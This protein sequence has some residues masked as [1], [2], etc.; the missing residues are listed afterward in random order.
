MSNADTLARIARKAGFKLYEWSGCYGGTLADNAERLLD[1]RTHYYDRG[2]RAYFGSRVTK[3]TTHSDGTILATCESVQHPSL[4]RVHRF[5]IFDVSGRV[6]ER[7]DLE[8]TQYR[9]ASQAQKAMYA[10]LDACDPAQILRDCIGNQINQ[11]TNALEDL[12]SAMTQLQGG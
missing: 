11:H 5:V 3:I 12:Q 10:W 2:T 4:G 1:G 6:I 8:E 9:R 7:P